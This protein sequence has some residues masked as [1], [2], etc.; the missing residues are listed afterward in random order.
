LLS[1]HAKVSDALDRL[2]K[3]ATC[4]SLSQRYQTAQDIAADLFAE[5]KEKQTNIFDSSL[6]VTTSG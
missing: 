2:V 6:E 5:F 1:G 3:K 4:L